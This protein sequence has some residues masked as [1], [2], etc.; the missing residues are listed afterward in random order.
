MKNSNAI[1]ACFFAALLSAC[2]ATGVQVKADQLT[3]FKPGVTTEAEV[4]AKLGR[5]IT[6]STNFDGSRTLAYYYAHYQTRPTSFIPVV[7]L[8]AGGSDMQT[9]TTI[10]RFDKDGRFI[11]SSST[12]SQHGTG[13]GLTAGRPIPQTDQP[14]QQP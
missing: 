4:V 12:E 10:I 8:I 3:E 5:P 6:T 7:G 14:R 11:S 9:N 1:A 2:A 13:T